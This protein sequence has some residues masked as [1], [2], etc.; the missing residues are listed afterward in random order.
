MKKSLALV[1][2]VVMLSALTLTAC[3]SKVE[4][5]T[6][7]GTGKGYKSDIEVKVTLEG[8]KIT[9]VEVVKHGDTPGISDAAIQDIPKAIVAKG[10]VD[11]VDTVSGATATSNGIIDAVK[12]A[13]SKKK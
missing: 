3:G 12:N 2:V 5:L 9:A 1:M 11:G 8:D 6:L 13:L 4:K 7:E 10:N